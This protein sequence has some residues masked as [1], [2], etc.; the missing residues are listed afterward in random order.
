MMPKTHEPLELCGRGRVCE[1]DGVI[2]WRKVEAESKLKSLPREV[3]GR[4]WP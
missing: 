3:D 4:R 1:V 2:D